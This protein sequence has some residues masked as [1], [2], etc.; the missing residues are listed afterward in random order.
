LLATHRESQPDRLRPMDELCSRAVMAVM[1]LRKCKRTRASGAT[2]L[3]KDMTGPS[4]YESRISGI[5][6][7]LS[8]TR[9][10]QI[11][12]PL[13]IYFVF[14]VGGIG[15]CYTNMGSKFFVSLSFV[16]PL[17]F[18][19]RRAH[20]RARRIKLPVTNRANEAVKILALNPF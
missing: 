4:Y 18:I 10:R 13:A 15:T 2:G 5:P 12:S 1:A 3:P 8:T 6:N 7:V 9:V 11:E 14:L 19:R 20:R 17:H 16:L